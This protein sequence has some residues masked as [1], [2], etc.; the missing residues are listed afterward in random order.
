MTPVTSLEYC[1]NCPDDFVA[2]IHSVK[3]KL[4]HQSASTKVW[5]H[6]LYEWMYNFINGYISY[7]NGCMVFCRHS[8]ARQMDA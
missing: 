5:M 8:V 4:P 2:Q 1:G 6:K 3:S 7:R